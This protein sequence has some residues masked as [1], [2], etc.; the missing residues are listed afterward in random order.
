M[1]K[2]MKYEFILLIMRKYS[3]NNNKIYGGPIV[4]IFRSDDGFALFLK[5]M[6]FSSNFPTIFIFHFR[7]KN[8]DV[9]QKMES[10]TLYTDPQD[11]TSESLDLKDLKQVMS[12][13]ES[14]Q[15]VQQ[16]L[17]AVQRQ[18]AN[19]KNAAP[20]KQLLLYLVR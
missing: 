13:A 11:T 19:S 10:L 8:M 17:V 2:K 18:I 7:T 16:K 1:L 6:G 9:A 14:F 12:K 4:E 3:F 5:E 20:P 15:T